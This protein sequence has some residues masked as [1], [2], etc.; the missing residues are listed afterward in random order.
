LSP[1]PAANSDADSEKERKVSEMFV[2]LRINASRGMVTFNRN[3]LE[4][5]EL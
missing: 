2:S 3:Q 1:Q 5:P 4:A